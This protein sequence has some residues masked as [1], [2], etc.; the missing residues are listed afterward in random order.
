M[1]VAG[2]GAAERGEGIGWCPACQRG[3]LLQDPR[4]KLRCPLCHYTET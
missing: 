1:S 2:E 3:P 4:C